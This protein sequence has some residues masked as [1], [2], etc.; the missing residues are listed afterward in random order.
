MCYAFL[1]NTKSEEY[2][3]D[4]NNQWLKWYALTGQLSQ[5]RPEGSKPDAQER[6]G[7]LKMGRVHAH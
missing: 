1:F 5:A 3:N 2:K 6:D 4:T 7:F